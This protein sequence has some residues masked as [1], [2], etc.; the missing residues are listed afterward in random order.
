MEGKQANEA[1]KTWLP[2]A[3]EE[4]GGDSCAE[5]GQLVHVYPFPLVKKYW[6]WLVSCFAAL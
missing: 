3:F 4:H 6:V 1:N 5:H 2:G